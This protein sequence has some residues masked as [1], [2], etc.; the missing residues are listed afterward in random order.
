VDTQ[1]QVGGT[2]VQRD[3]AGHDSD[4][5]DVQV[6]FVIPA[7]FKAWCHICETGYMSIDELTQHKK[8]KHQVWKG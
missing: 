1:E 8:D 4:S 6:P 5:G 7:P 2:Q 3:S